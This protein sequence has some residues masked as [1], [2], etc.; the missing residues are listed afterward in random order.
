MELFRQEYEANLPKNYGKLAFERLQQREIEKLGPQ[1]EISLK[2]REAL[3]AQHSF[4]SSESEQNITRL[5]RMLPDDEI[6]EYFAHIPPGCTALIMQSWQTVSDK[7]LRSISMTVG[8]SLE[9]LDLSYS[10]I[11]LFH[12]EILLARVVKLKVLRINGCPNFDPGCMSI[13]NRV[14]AHHVTELY[15]DGCITFK[16]DPLLILG[17]C[18]GFHAPK[19]SH[20]MVLSLANC[21]VEDK[22]LG[23]VIA[24]CR[25]IEFLNLC[26][27]SKL[28]DESVCSLIKQNKRLEVVNLTGC[29]KL[30]N[31]VVLALSKHCKRL[32]SLNISKMA[33]VGDNAVVS[34]LLSCPQL[35]ALN[36]AGLRKLNET[37]LCVIAEHCQDVLCTLNIT[38]C[39]KITSNGLDAIIEGFPLVKASATYVGFQPH[40]N[41]LELRLRSMFAIFAC[42]WLFCFVH[43]LTRCLLFVVCCLL[44]VQTSCRV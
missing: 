11:G 30:S 1:K 10:A 34:L 4:N 43:F 21:P 35:Q 20:I 38:G 44:P 26:E 40:D 13:V 32:Q 23:G 36:L 7:V 5:L 24:C 41:Y 29:L 8:D 22:G 19:L 12:L 28:G 14:S 9:E 31:A 42:A 25:H 33:K 17:G 2:V 18:I 3:D 16:I 15:A 37:V 39:E 27:C 6:C